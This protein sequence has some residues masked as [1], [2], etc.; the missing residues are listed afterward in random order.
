MDDPVQPS[1]RSRLAA[2]SLVVGGAVTGITPLALAR[3]WAEGAPPE[4]ADFLDPARFRLL[5]A[6]AETVIPR[7]DT[8]GAVEAGVPE[9]IDFLLANWASE[10]TR[11]TFSGAMDTIEAR[12]R[13]GYGQPFVALDAPGRAA[14]LTALDREFAGR[15]REGFGLVKSL[16]VFGY[17]TSE[18]GATQELQWDQIP[19]TYGCRPMAD[20]AR[21]WATDGW[22]DEL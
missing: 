13:E 2:V 19:G 14:V 6:V 3:Q 20:D 11:R 10:P 7:T 18:I 1:R 12:A 17:Y 8:P 9:F 4:T 21:D 5:G 16:L 22:R 15:P